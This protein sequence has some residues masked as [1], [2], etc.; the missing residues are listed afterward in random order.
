[1]PNARSPAIL[2]IDL[3]TSAVKLAAVTTRGVILGGEVEPL[4]L[5][6]LP[7]GGAEQDPESWWSAIVRAAR[8]LLDREGVS[9]AD[10]VGVNCSCQWSGTVAV[11]EQGRPLHPAILWMDSRGAP[12]VRRLTRGLV[13]IEGYGL[14]KLYTWLRL[15]GGVPSM[16]G[17]DPVGHILYLRHEHPEIYRNTYKFLEPKDWLNLRL[18]GKFAASHDSIT[19]HWVT[20][21]RDLSRVGYDDRL[22]AM[23]GLHREKLPD[24]LPAA[25]V[26]GPL[27]PEVARELGLGEHVQVVTGAPDI[28]AAAIGSGAVRDFES[29]LC[30]GTSSWL[31]CHVPYKRADVLH[32]LGTVPSAI[33]GRYMLLNEQESAGICLSQLKD[34]LFDTQD[35]AT[36]PNSQ[37]IYARF[38]QAAARVPAGSDQVIFLPWLNGER[39]PVEDPRMR[40]GFLNQSLQTTR[41]HLVRAV[42][43]GVAYNS[44]WLLSYVEPF[45]GR[46]LEGIRLIGGGAR[47][48]VWCQ[49]LADV[50]DRPIH[51]V[52][53]PVLANA[54]GAAFQAALALKHLTL[55]EMPGLVPITHIYE[56]NATHR[57]LYDELFH[58]F[59]NLYKA[60]KAIFARLNRS[61]SA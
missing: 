36:V 46:K 24:L 27:R 51:Q 33:P 25:S 47:S 31:S 40:G 57:R 42:M 9:A 21:N 11:D 60:N 1:M 20:D 12:H 43:E 16:S 34:L 23:T 2:A 58:E 50:L 17:K 7:E 18:S 55:E 52:D 59:L 14:G 54:R 53:E 19:L 49:I 4:P 38:E 15:T 28:M 3:G 48:R 44:R 6:L 30:V 22:L 29:H 10:I 39:S 32:Q 56:P 45:L 35:A 8:R 61:R 41:G 13:S 5:S 37:E 26:V